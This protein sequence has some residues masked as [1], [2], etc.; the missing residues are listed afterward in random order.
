MALLAYIGL[1]HV[2][3]DF[4]VLVDEYEHIWDFEGD[5]IDFKLGDVLFGKLRPYLAKAW[6]ASFNGKG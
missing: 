5:T 6:P 2:K 1:E 4:G 3:S